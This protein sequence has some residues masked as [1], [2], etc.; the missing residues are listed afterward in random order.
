MAN[1]FKKAAILTDLHLGL[2]SNSEMHNDDCLHFIQWFIEK[3]KAEG[4]DTC[5]CLGDWH[6]H[7][8]SINIQ[9]L[10]YSMMCLEALSKGFSQVFT[11]T[12][13]H[14]LFFREKRPAG[15]R[16][17]AARPRA[18]QAANAVGSIRLYRHRTVG[19]ADPFASAP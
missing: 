11:I 15:Q 12:G 6:N 1:L 18:V 3:A 8:S 16:C 13:N 9:T 17:Q 4:C 14:D 7:R 5:I 19:V 10:H 2:K